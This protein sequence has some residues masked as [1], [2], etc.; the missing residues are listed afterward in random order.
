MAMTPWPCPH[1]GTREGVTADGTGEAFRCAGCGAEWIELRPLL[2]LVHM[3]TGHS[4]A[5]E[6]QVFPVGQ[7]RL[8]LEGV[9]LCEAIHGQALRMD[10]KTRGVTRDGKRHRRK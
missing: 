1:C 10:A 3:T 9:V 5:E 4:L 8:G 6:M 2:R 7:F